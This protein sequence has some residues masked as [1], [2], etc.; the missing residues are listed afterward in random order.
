MTAAQDGAGE[1]NPEAAPVTKVEH[2][3][4]RVIT[5]RPLNMEDFKH[6]KNQVCSPIELPFEMWLLG[7]IHF[8]FCYVNYSRT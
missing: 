1:R 4:E 2:K 5:L 8:G 6:A 3:E 7:M